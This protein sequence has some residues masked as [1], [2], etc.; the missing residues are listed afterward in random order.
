MRDDYD[1]AF[2]LENKCKC[3]N[4]KTELGAVFC[5][6]DNCK[7]FVNAD[8]E[9]NYKAIQETTEDLKARDINAFFCVL[10]H[11]WFEGWGCNPYPLANYDYNDYEYNN[12]CN[13]C[14]MLVLEQRLRDFGILSSK[15]E[16]LNE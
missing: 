15:E 13:D 16:V 5:E 4:C 6:C 9:L 1:I 7:I 8:K 11:Q 14:D 3:D 10:C 2:S 12:C